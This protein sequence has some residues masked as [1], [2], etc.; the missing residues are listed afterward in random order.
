MYTVPVHPVAGSALITMIST[1]PSHDPEDG[2]RKSIV[3]DGP[4]G[5]RRQ[6]YAGR[7]LAIVTGLNDGRLPALASG[8]RDG[9]NKETADSYCLRTQQTI[10]QQIKRNCFALRSH[11]DE[12]SV[13]MRQ[14]TPKNLPHDTINDLTAVFNKQNRLKKKQ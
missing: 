3:S 9:R 5:R 11:I 1:F 8:N 14:N 10:L 7:Q 2:L 4:E 13:Q 6:I 12:A